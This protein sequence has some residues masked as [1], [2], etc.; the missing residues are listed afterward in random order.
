MKRILTALLIASL[1]IMPLAACGTASTTAPQA[2]DVTVD[3]IV[4]AFKARIIADLEKEGIAK[5]EVFGPGE[6]EP[7]L[8]ITEDLKKPAAERMLAARSEERRVG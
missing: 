3:Q 2:P 4:E 6:G 7:G 5:D 1:C 8:F